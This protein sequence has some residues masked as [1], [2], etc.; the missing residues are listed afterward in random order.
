MH[1]GTKLTYGVEEGLLA[2]VRHGEVEVGSAAT[3]RKAAMIPEARSTGQAPLTPCKA[4]SVLFAKAT[5]GA[6]LRCRCWFAFRRTEPRD[7]HSKGEQPV[8]KQNGKEHRPV[9]DDPNQAR[10]DSR[11][12]PGKVD[13]A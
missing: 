8:P 9:S 7:V 5:L 13:S 1:G 12:P 3:K 6:R 11:V 10:L 2:G 4:V